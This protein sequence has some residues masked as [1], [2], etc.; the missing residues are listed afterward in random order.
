MGKGLEEKLWDLWQKNQ[1]IVPTIIIINDYEE[2]VDQP[3]EV[4]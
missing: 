2:E 4:E 1:P 3:V